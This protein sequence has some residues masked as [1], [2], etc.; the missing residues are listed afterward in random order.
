MN[1]KI[2]VFYHND[3]DGFGAAWT[4]WTKFGN[5]AEYASL[6]HQGPLPL[7]VK[8]K[9]VFFLDYCPDSDEEMKAILKESKKVVVIDHHISVK[10]C[11]KMASECLFDANNSG[12]V[13]AW[14]Y[15]YPNKKIP[16]LLSHIEDIDLWK[17]KMKESNEVIAS[18]ET[19][20]MDFKI[21]NK[22]TSDFEDIKNRK[23]YIEEGKAI[24]KYKNKIVAKLVKKAEEVVF[25]GHKALVVNSP[26]L[27]SEIGHQIY[28]NKNRF[29]IIWS[30]GKD[31]LIVSMRSNGNVDVSKI[32]RKYGGGGH[33]KAAAFRL[34]SDIKFPWRRV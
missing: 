3:E 26:I 5:R 22:I 13:L 1:K 8:N 4:A 34:K 14:K 31:G 11:A 20:P 16:R 12:A 33:K 30:Y 18:L 28:Q 32:A 15:F 9:E 29:G 17:F 25:E 19:Y 24:I 6:N 2:I 27:N 7:S 10:N 23:K 21:W